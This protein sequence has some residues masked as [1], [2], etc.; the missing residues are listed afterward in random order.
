[1]R[2]KPGQPIEQLVFHRPI[3]E[4]CKALIK[5]GLLLAGWE[6]PCVDPE[7]LPKDCLWAQR[8]AIPPVLLTRWVIH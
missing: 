1:M 4:Y 3:Q 6:E 2:S 5:N 8:R 7:E